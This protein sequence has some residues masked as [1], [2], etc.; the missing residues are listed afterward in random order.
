MA[1]YGRSKNT[2]RRQSPEKAQD[3]TKFY[4]KFKDPRTKSQI[5]YYFDEEDIYD[6]CIP[7]NEGDI[8]YDSG[9]ISAVPTQAVPKPVQPAQ[10]KKVA[11]KL[12]KAPPPLAKISTL[13]SHSSEKIRPS[14][15]HLSAIKVDSKITSAKQNIDLDDSFED[16]GYMTAMDIKYIPDDLKSKSVEPIVELQVIEEAPKEIKP[17]SRNFQFRTAM[18]PVDKSNEVLIAEE[19][20]KEVFEANTKPN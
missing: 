4:I 14:S 7:L 16:V 15:V 10:N 13:K 9:K 6:P 20:S 18:E 1:K 3:D 5:F 17:A 12:D 19:L 8:V 11:G 2:A